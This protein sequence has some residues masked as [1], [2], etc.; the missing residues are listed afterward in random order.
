MGPERPVY[1]RVIYIG[2]TDVSDSSAEI[3]LLLQGYKW[4][5]L[6]V[7]IDFCQ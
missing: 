3:E 1:S 5:G 6:G 4:P 2:L 7:T